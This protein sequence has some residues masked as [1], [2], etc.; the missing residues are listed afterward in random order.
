[1]CVLQLED[2][3]EYKSKNFGW[4]TELEPKLQTL[5][6]RLLGNEHMQNVFLADHAA[7]WG[8]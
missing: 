3:L 1:M 2:D 7:Q 8:I 4:E 5:M 6:L